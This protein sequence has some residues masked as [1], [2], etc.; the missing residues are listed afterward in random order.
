MA[1]KLDNQF[2]P[3]GRLIMGSL[4]EKQT[5]DFDGKLIPEE[6]QRYFFGVAVP[7]DAPG[8][9]EIINAL[10]QMAATDYAQVPLVMAQINLGLDAKD[11]AWKVSDGD[12][13]T[14][15]KKTGQL[16]TIPD[17]MKGCY[18]FKFA[19][20]FE[21]SACD[22]NGN[23]INRADIKN[24]DYVDVM[25]N[26][27]T[28]GKMDDMAGIYLN[29]NAIRRLGYGDPIS[30]GMSASQAF[31][32]R[33]ASVPAG[34]TAMPTAGGATP[35]PAAAAGNGAQGQMPSASAGGMPGAG[36][37]GA[38]PSTPTASPHTDI[39]NGPGGGG[40]GGMPGM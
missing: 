24:G 26:A 15:D 25:F 5:K 32:N 16:R 23:D 33:A 28:N 20:N 14:Y 11:F 36:T 13:Q 2:T 35:P 4:T 1:T 3:G 12:A 27:T 29:P 40:G 8:I 7:K 21:V 39:L 31:A 9:K 37:S 10:W 19:T 30:T 18:V 38:A 34:A 17:Y 6:K 22:V